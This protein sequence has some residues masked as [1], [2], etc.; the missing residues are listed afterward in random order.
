MSSF[1]LVKEVKSM[2]I[3]FVRDAPSI[4]YQVLS[5]VIRVNQIISKIKVL[6]KAI[7]TTDK[8][9]KMFKI[10]KI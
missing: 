6:D 3:S 4:K 1:E 2:C 5:N 9:S 8:C 10:Q 7:S